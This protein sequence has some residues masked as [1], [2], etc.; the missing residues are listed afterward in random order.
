M[1]EIHEPIAPNFQR[2]RTTFDVHIEELLEGQVRNGIRIPVLA[3]Q[4]LA[5]EARY[6]EWLMRV[7]ATGGSR[8]TRPEF[9]V[10]E[11][12]ERLGFRSPW[13]EP[14]GFDFDFQVPIGFDP[15]THR[16]NATADIFLR[17]TVPETVIRV[18]GE[19]WHFSDS[20]QIVADTLEKKLLETMGF[21]VV[22]ILAQDT[23]HRGRLEE[24]VRM[25]IIGFSVDPDGRMQV[26]E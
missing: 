16:E 8:G 3:D 12:L 14:P 10:F 24:V 1:V 22:D 6:L 20:A 13:S 9:Y 25:A 2:R 19:F 7:G 15:F 5:R 17:F 4:E 26:F 18:Q 11:E 23:L 21:R